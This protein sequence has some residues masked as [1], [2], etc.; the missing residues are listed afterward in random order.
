[1]LKNYGNRSIPRLDNTGTDAKF[2]KK[3]AKM[4][5]K[6]GKIAQFMQGKTGKYGRATR[7]NQSK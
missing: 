6:D 7:F 2:S 4:F 1:M 5:G 3:Q